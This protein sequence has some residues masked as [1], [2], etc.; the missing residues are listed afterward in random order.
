V[1]RRI[2]EWTIHWAQTPRASQALALIAFA[3]SSFFPVPPDVL[4]IAMCLARPKRSFLYAALGAFFSVLGGMLG[5]LIGYA[6]W[7]AAAPFF[8][9]YIPGFSEGAFNTVASLYQEN[10]FWT[11][12]TAGFTPI[13]Y[14]VF[15][16]TGGVCKISFATLVAA[17]A[18]GRSG[19]FFLVGGLIYFFGEPVRVFIEKYLGWLTI[20]FAILLI[21]GFVLIKRFLH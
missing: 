20:A 3:E 18:L 17:S 6:L 10:A 11:V 2:Y 8:F 14:K 12:F 13:P 5:Y 19:R 15:T 21:G 4:L 7:G 1:H 9:H 16:I